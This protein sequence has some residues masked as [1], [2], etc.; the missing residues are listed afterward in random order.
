[1][2]KYIL[3]RFQSIK[4]FITLTTGIEDLANSDNPALR[5]VAARRGTMRAFEERRNTFIDAERRRSTIRRMSSVQHT[6]RNL[7]L[8]RSSVGPD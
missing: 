1:M 3:S 8:L 6:V 2:G 5:R 4:R 7:P